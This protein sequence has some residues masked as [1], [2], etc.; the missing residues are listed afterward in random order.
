MGY[1]SF[2]LFVDCECHPAI[3]EDA[4]DGGCYATVES[5]EPILVE[6]VG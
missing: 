2:G 4:E 6:G 5:F 1:L 3:G